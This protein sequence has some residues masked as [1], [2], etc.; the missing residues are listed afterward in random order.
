M[1]RGTDPHDWFYPKW[2]KEVETRLFPSSQNS[3]PFNSKRTVFLTP[4]PGPNCPALYLWNSSNLP[5]NKVYPF[6]NLFMFIWQSL[7]Q[8]NKLNQ[9]TSFLLTNFANFWISTAQNSLR[10]GTSS[11]VA[12]ARVD[13]TA[14][15]A[16]LHFGSAV[17]ASRLF[18]WRAIFYLV[19]F[20]LPCS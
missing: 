1:C 2:L 6:Q 16:S 8:R 9:R 11:P 20:F 17:R 18:L 15:G 12:V 7:K 5:K 10:S 3:V 4:T 19:I 14:S 13:R